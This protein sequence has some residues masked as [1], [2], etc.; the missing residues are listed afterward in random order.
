MI[1][2][3][4]MTVP[5]DAVDGIY[6]SSVIY[7]GTGLTIVLSEITGGTIVSSV[8]VDAGLHE[9]N[10]SYKLTGQG[11]IEDARGVIV[12][13]DL[14]TLSSSLPYGIFEF[15]P[16]A[17]RMEPCTV[18]PDLELV[19][20]LRAVS[21]SGE[22]SDKLTGTVE[23][24]AGYNV[25]LTY[26]APSTEHPYGGIRI[27]GICSDD[28]KEDCPCDTI[29]TPPPPIRTI[30]GVAADSSGNLQFLADSCLEITPESNGLKFDDTCAKPCC[31]CTELEF[32]HSNLNLLEKSVDTLKSRAISLQSNLATFYVNVIGSI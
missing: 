7:S 18:R 4:I 22:A 11:V 16:E 32:I 3:F 12:L 28:F 9:V 14:T 8:T 26:V 30:N 21:A 13:G 6:V 19:R 17:T 20:A 5:A 23:L 31:G 1:V 15:A 29:Y 27:D 25:R 10:Q 2:D 24:I